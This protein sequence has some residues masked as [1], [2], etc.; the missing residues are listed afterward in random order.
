MI[1]F[2]AFIG[3]L[4]DVY[5]QYKKKTKA[6]NVIVNIINEE[7][8]ENLIETE[9]VTKDEEPLIYLQFLICFSLRKNYMKV[10][11]LSNT[12]GQLDCLHGIRF[13][14]IGLYLIIVKIQEFN[15]KKNLF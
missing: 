1:L 4:I 14:S 7:E 13:F 5:F 2:I 12:E 11:N 8:N 3:T 10:F 6:K 9:I 15:L